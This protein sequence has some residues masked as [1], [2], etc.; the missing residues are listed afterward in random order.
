MSNKNHKAP[1]KNNV[2]LPCL[3]FFVAVGVLMMF[4][5]GF[6][7]SLSCGLFDVDLGS[8]LPQLSFAPI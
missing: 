2:H 7:A 3:V 6:V 8:V 5:V 1:T 4:E